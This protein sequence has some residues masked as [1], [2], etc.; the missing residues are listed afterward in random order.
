MIALT[1]RMPAPDAAYLT[2]IGH[3]YRCIACKAG[4]PCPV[5]VRLNHVWREVRR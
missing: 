5:A 1:K 4:P 3:T 2:L